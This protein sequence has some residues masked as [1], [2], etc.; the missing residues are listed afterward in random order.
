MV[1]NHLP[2]ATL[3]ETAYRILGMHALAQLLRMQEGLAPD[4][5]LDEL[6]MMCQDIN[7]L[8]IDFS[9]RLQVLQDKDSTMN[10]LTDL[11]CFVQMV[12]LSVEEDLLED[13]KQLFKPHL[14]ND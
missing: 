5:G 6:S 10:A 9:K 13:L 2:F 1:V 7:E 8:N 11:D 4:L 3:Q 14:E 12:D